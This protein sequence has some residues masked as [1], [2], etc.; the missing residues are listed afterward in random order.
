MTVKFSVHQISRSFFPDS[1]VKSLGAY[2]TPEL[3]F[4]TN[5][6]AQ[7]E[8]CILYTTAYYIRQNTVNVPATLLFYYQVKFLI[9]TYHTCWINAVNVLTASLSGRD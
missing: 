8:R 2:Y 9:D 3:R 1:S 5:F 7:S 4:F 6:Q